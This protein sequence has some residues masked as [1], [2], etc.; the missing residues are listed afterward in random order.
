[1]VFWD[2]L[3]IIFWLMIGA[4]FTTQVFMPMWRR[5]R[6]FPLF[7]RERDLE[8]ELE[9]VKQEVVEAEIEQQIVE[10]RKHVEHIRKGEGHS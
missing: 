3:E 9:H 8:S 5:T 6:L 10:E 1:M 2:I 7:R 4:F